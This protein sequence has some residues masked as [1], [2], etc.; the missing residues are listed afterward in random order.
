MPFSVSSLFLD[1][2]F[3]TSSINDSIAPSLSPSFPPFLHYFLLFS[4]HSSFLPSLPSVSLPLPPLPPFLLTLCPSAS[5]AR[6]STDNLTFRSDSCQTSLNG[7]ALD[8]FESLSNPNKRTLNIRISNFIPQISLHLLE[9]LLFLSHLF[10]L[11]L[12][13]WVERGSRLNATQPK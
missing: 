2:S 13:S 1:V 10:H 4:L 8:V 5:A 3:L 11:L 9:G 6:P 7:L 12:P